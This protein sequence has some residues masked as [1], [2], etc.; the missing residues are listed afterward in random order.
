[1]V[2]ADDVE[3]NQRSNEQGTVRSLG[4]FR[5]QYVD[6]FEKGSCPFM[7]TGLDIDVRGL[8]KLSVLRLIQSSSKRLLDRA[9]GILGGAQQAGW[10]S[11]GEQDELFPISP[12]SL[13]RLQ[14]A[15]YLFLEGDGCVVFLPGG[16]T[17]VG[18]ERREVQIGLVDEDGDYKDLL[19]ELV[20][21]GMVLKSTW[22][23]SHLEPAEQEHDAARRMLYEEAAVAA[24]AITHKRGW[25]L[26]TY[27]TAHHHHLLSGDLCV[28]HP[29]EAKRLWL[30]MRDKSTQLHRDRF[31]CTCEATFGRLAPGPGAASTAVA[32]QKCWLDHWNKC[33]ENR[34]RYPAYA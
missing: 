27:P 5:M 15:N 13:Q 4:V 7:Q 14:V 17:S 26:I 29:K 21:R 22:V 3:V 34:Y 1:M 12:E 2:D 24:A 6:A 9:K 32:W 18:G 8:Y 33:E 20:R 19:L 16:R 30:K 28:M 31:Q 23:N 10:V 25:Q 11:C